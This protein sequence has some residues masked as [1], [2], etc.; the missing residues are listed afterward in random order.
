M[1]EAE[2]D[3]KTT[4]TQDMNQIV[5]D[6]TKYMHEQQYEAYRERYLQTDGTPR[7]VEGVPSLLVSDI[8]PHRQLYV[9]S[10]KMSYTVTNSADQDVVPDKDIQVVIEFQTQQTKQ[11]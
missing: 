2:T 1:S 3:Q 9:S 4:G 10:V 5:L 6:I 7:I 8:L 11:L